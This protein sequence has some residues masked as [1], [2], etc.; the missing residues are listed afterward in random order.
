MRLSDDKVNH[1]S[2]LVA[3]ELESN[4]KVEFLKDKNSIRLLIRE[5]IKKE[6][7]LD[8]D[9]DKIVK[10]KIPKKM[11]EGSRQWDIMYDKIFQEEM[12]KRGR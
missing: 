5:V 8:T 11:Q 12:A 1:L 3:D 6:L 9:I 7:E 10:S 2:H 4:E